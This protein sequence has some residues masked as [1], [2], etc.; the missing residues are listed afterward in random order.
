MHC[1]F[2]VIVDK[3]SVVIGVRF[4]LTGP[5]FFGP[6]SGGEDT[7]FGSHIVISSS[8][9]SNDSVILPSDCRLS[10]YIVVESSRV[11]FG[12]LEE[13]ITFGRPSS[14]RFGVSRT[15]SGRSGDFRV[16]EAGVGSCVLETLMI[17]SY[18]SL[19][20]TSFVTILVVVS[21]SSTFRISVV[22]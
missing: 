18:C 12:F 19:L 20:I 2:T 17:C 21:F 5:V 10:V 15:R 22:E 9:H 7:P 8:V 14:L 13:G 16:G 1:S 4:S 3:N 11:G 6:F